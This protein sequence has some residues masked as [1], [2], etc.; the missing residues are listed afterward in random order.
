MRTWRCVLLAALLC[1][2][3]FATRELFAAVVFHEGFESPSVGPTSNA[4]SG[5][6]NN[7]GI[8]T[9]EYSG[10]EAPL[11]SSFVG[12]SGHTWVVDQENVDIFVQ[13]TQASAAEG[14]QY[15]ELVGRAPGSMYT[16][17]NVAPGEYQLS[18]AL[19]KC[20]LA[21]SPQTVLVAFD[22]AIVGGGPFTFSTATTLPN[23]TWDT[24]DVP[25][26]IPDL[27]QGNTD[28]TLRFTATTAYGEAGPIID[29]VQILSISEP[30]TL[31]LLAIGLV[32]LMAYAWRKRRAS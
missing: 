6:W 22:G 29:N 18:F 25:I 3:Q 26:Q 31:P 5:I 12:D 32:T 10:V 9:P 1:A 19:S 7:Y 17:V 30:C 16:V 20:F 21:S 11:A 14:Q 23:T 28:H 2:I 8:E 4:G 15:V 13:G 24:V 27:G